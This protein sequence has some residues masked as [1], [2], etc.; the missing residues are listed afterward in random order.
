MTLQSEL[1]AATPAARRSSAPACRASLVTAGCVG[2]SPPGSSACCWCGGDA[3]RLCYDFV[4]AGS[5]E[6]HSSDRK[7]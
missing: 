2:V 1:S 6:G 4:K 3:D 7:S 5:V